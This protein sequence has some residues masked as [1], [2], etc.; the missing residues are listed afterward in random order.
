MIQTILERFYSQFP[1][2][3]QDLLS[4]SAI[5]QIGLFVLLCLLALL[6][7]KIIQ[8][9]LNRWEVKLKPEPLLE[10]YPWLNH[11]FVIVRRGLLPL[12]AWLLGK[13]A[14]D[15]FKSRNWQYNIL[16]WAVPFL[17]I[18]LAY[19]VVSV[20]LKLQL[21]QEQA[22]VWRK[23]IL[24]PLALAIALLHSLR[25]LDK[26][27][28]WRVPVPI[29]GINLTT[30]TILMALVIVYLSLLFSRVVEQFLGER[31]LPKTGIDKSVTEVIAALAGYTIIATGLFSAFS[32]VGIPLTTFTVIAGGLSVGLGFGLQELM[33]NF[34]TG[35]V[36][37][38]EGSIRPGDVIR[39]GDTVGVVE[40]IGIR[41]MR[42]TDIDNVN[43]IIPNNSFLSDVVTN[44][45][46]NDLKV[47][48]HIAVGVTYSANPREVEEALLEAATHPL[49]LPDPA[50]S[51]Y[52]TD[53]GDSSLNF[54]LL[55]W[56]TDALQ[57]PQ[58]SSDL[59]Y[60]IWDALSTRKIEIPFPQRDIYIRGVTGLQEV[61]PPTG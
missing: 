31:F 2:G 47:R 44:F 45:S 14:I 61:L 34:V 41:S 25:L 19:R 29:S 23:Q 39:V 5:R 32:V 42:I 49:I 6:L 1:G 21:P 38:F 16:E 20:F 58:L 7:K 37:L 57:M 40:N 52:F 28:L 9:I 60:K 51:V 17:I 35:F 15:L 11:L 10:Q 53:F 24:A 36:L 8:P 56:T 43:L 55:V 30:G 26:L 54:E 50:P 3:M 4:Q 48:L 33:S 13:A 18:W 27:W 12:T 46:Q 22:Q 59:R